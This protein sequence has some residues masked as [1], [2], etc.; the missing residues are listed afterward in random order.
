MQT[1]AWNFLVKGDKIK[2]EVPEKHLQ[3]GWSSFV[4]SYIPIFADFYV[5]S[6]Y[7]VNLV[8]LHEIWKAT[9]ISFQAS[10]E[11]CIT[12]DARGNGLIIVS[13]H[14]GI[15]IPWQPWDWRPP[16]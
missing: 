8:Q 7:M 1:Q 13:F 5:L 2:F 3:L 4:W 11:N 10:R 16:T 12:D 6:K 14:N 15:Y 9:Y